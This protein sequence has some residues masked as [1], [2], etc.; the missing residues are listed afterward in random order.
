[1]KSSSEFNDAHNVE[2]AMDG[3]LE[4]GIQVFSTEA[5]E[6]SWMQV[7]F[8]RTFWVSIFRD[9]SEKVFPEPALL[10]PEY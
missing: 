9:T 2:K 6:F 10:L 1:M 5:V 4:H 8:S 3:V 7:D